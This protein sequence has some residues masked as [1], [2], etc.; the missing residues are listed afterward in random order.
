MRISTLVFCVLKKI[1]F[2][3]LRERERAQAL[4]E[5]EEERQAANKF[6]EFVKNSIINII[7]YFANNEM[8][9]KSK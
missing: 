6:I 7:N 5:G 9:L 3:Y 8:N 2:V 1:L 4:G